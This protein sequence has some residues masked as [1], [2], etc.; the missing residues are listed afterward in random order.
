MAAQTAASTI[1]ENIG[2]ITLH[3]FTFT[4]VTGADTFNTGLGTGLIAAFASGTL[5]GG[6]TVTVSG[7]NANLGTGANVGIVT[8]TTNLAAVPVTLFALSKS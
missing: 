7:V 8:F 3:I 5:A 2:S 4:S 6:T 1:R